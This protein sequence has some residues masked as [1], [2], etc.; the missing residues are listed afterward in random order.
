VQYSTYGRHIVTDIWGVDFNVLNDVDYLEQIMIEAAAHSRATVL[1]SS[2]EKFEPCGC[3]IVILLSES[4]LSIHTY[5]E[6]GFAAL[7]CYTCGRDKNPRL[8]I[9]HLVELLKPS[10]VYTKTIIRGIKELD[11]V[12]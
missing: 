1:S 4:H 10:E 8:A 7:D 9:T 6:K 12:D 5:P 3:T 2:F 11:I